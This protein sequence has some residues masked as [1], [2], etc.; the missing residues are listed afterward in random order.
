MGHA[1]LVAVALLLAVCAPLPACSSLLGFEELQPGEADA[2]S[3]AADAGQD[4]GQETGP[5][6][7]E[8]AQDA[9]ADDGPDAADD[10][11]ASVD[12]GC[13]D[14]TSSKDNC[15]RCG[16]SCLGGEC[17]QGMCQPFTL[18]KI[19]DGAWGLA[20]D[21]TTVYVAGLLNNEI[22]RVAK[23]TGAVLSVDTAS[24]ILVPA[25]VAV[26]ASSMVWSNRSS[27]TGSVASCPI[28]GCGGNSPKVLVPV[29]DRPNG[30]LVDGDTLYW[31]ESYGG[32]L[33]SA[34]L[35]DGSSPTVL[36]PSSLGYQPYRMALH[37]EYLYFTDVANGHVVRVPKSGGPAV[38]LGTSSSPAGIAVT[39]DTVYWADSQDMTGR[40]LSVP[41]ADPPDAGAAPTDLA[42][43]QDVAFSVAVDDVNV[44]WV[45]SATS[46]TA[47]GAVR[48]CPRS[49]CPGNGPITLAAQ[50]A[51]PVDLALDESAIYVTIF[52]LDSGPSDG[53]LLKIAKP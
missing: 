40:I 36:V 51:Y 46:T 6:A 28:T 50:L 27:G 43:Q 47:A 52:G 53:A 26:G 25:W 4:A 12:G 15:G 48:M 3:A 44:Y 22:V 5:D 1:N 8:D 9:I 18:T 19:D 17:A 32:T 30:V 33:N 38:I 42:W 49:G 29:A 23:N 39:D 41:N 16:H 35:S 34:H 10:G 11:E 7:G 31:A 2:G 20:V 13:G 24:D 45:A 14:T 37:G 21:G